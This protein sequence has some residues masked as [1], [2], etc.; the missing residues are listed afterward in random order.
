MRQQSG[1]INETPWPGPRRPCCAQTGSCGGRG[2]VARVH[3]RIAVRASAAHH[4]GAEHVAASGNPPPPPLP[5][6]PPARDR[7]STASTGVSSRGSSGG[8]TAHAILSRAA[9]REEAFEDA[10]RQ[11][12]REAIVGLRQFEAVQ[13]AR[14]RLEIIA[15]FEGRR[16]AVRPAE[17]FAIHAEKVFEMAGVKVGADSAATRAFGN[18]EQKLAAAVGVSGVEGIASEAFTTIS[19]IT[20]GPAVGGGRDWRRVRPRARLR[21]QG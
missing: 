19:R 21:V 10:R 15:R 14:W 8:G 4:Q 6:R 18:D 13:I 2:L 1:T 20:Y 11:K 5:P 9:T 12:C 7:P 3:E 16:F 17:R